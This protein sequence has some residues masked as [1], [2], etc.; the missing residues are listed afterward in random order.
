MY[1]KKIA[2]KV[3]KFLFL[4]LCCLYM[5]YTIGKDAAQRDRRNNEKNHVQIDKRN[6]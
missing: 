4:I 6:N 2:L 5:G 1:N 3:V